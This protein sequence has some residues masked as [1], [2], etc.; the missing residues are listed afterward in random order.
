M[1]DTSLRA[2]IVDDEPHIRQYLGLVLQ[3]VGWELR[4]QA[5]SVAEARTIHAASPCDLI[6]LDVNLP[7]EDGLVWLR[8][9]RAE[10]DET[11]VVMISSQANAA[12]IMEAAELGADAYLR[13]DMKREELAAELRRVIDDTLG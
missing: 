7:G 6:L 10:G 8:E 12:L 2:L 9:L 13:K 1:S 5:G 4:E 3:S 11:V